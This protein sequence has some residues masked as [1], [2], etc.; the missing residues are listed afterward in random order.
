MSIPAERRH[1]PEWPILTHNVRLTLYKSSARMLP[2]SQQSMM[3]SRSV[4]HNSEDLKITSVLPRQQ[5]H[6]CGV[7]NQITCLSKGQTTLIS[8]RSKTQGTI[9]TYSWGAFVSSLSVI[10]HPGRLKER[11]MTAKLV[12]WFLRD[13]Q[14]SS[15]LYCMASNK[16]NEEAS[17]RNNN[18]TN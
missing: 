18:S 1:F 12:S 8:S 2:I 7:E 14:W 5:F 16:V 15:Y 9:F 4:A 17:G 3:R 6:F 13:I 11:A 10:C